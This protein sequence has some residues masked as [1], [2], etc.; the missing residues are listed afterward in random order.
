MAETSLRSLLLLTFYVSLSSAISSSQV[1]FVGFLNEQRTFSALL[2]VDLDFEVGSRN[3]LAS[4]NR[5]CKD[6]YATVSKVDQGPNG[7]SK[8]G[9]WRTLQLLLPVQ[10]PHQTSPELHL[11]YQDEQ[12]SYVALPQGFQLPKVTVNEVLNKPDYD[13]QQYV[14]EPLEGKYCSL[15]FSSSKALLYMRQMHI[16]RPIDGNILYTR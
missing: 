6:I 4:L 15:R 14:L 16:H 13:E 2:E 9:L 3:W 11:C 12:G 10:R 7:S 1:T 8:A 5:D